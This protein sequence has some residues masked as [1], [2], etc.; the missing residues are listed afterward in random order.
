V[1]VYED[2]KSPNMIEA[3]FWKTGQTKYLGLVK[4][5]T[6]DK[7]KTKIGKV[8]GITGEETEIRLESQDEVELVNLRTKKSLGRGR[9]HTDRFRPWEGNVYEVIF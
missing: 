9:V 6:L 8:R 3:L 1:R 5:P 2:G 4:N 7:D